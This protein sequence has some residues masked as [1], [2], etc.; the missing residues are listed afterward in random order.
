[1]K[2]IEKVHRVIFHHLPAMLVNCK[3]SSILPFHIYF[4]IL[5][6]NTNVD[7]MLLEYDMDED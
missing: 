7:C 5:D 6:T 2:I 1:M 3:S 4:H